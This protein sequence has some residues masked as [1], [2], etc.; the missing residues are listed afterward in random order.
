MEVPMSKKFARG[1][2]L[3]LEILRIATAALR[4]VMVL[5]E[6]LNKAANCDARK[7]SVQIQVA[8]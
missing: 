3:V 7:L 8:R 5:M 6:I 2:R 1:A 4:L